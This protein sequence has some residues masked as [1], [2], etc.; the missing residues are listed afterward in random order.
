MPA[1]IVIVASA[2]G[3]MF[4]VCAFTL[5]RVCSPGRAEPSPRDSRR[6]LAEP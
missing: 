5:A 2:V 1:E 6:R 3:L 4:I